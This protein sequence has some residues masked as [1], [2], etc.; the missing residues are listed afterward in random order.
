MKYGDIWVSAGNDPR[1]ESMSDII[2]MFQ[3]REWVNASLSGA[4]GVLPSMSMNRSII[5]NYSLVVE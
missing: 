3:A 4:R 5:P 2:T 1:Y